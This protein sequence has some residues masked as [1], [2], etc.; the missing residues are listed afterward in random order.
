MSTT[1]SGSTTLGP[2]QVAIAYTE[3]DIITPSTVGFNLTVDA[4]VISL[5]FTW[6]G[7]EFTHEGDIPDEVIGIELLNMT[8]PGD[9]CCEVWVKYVSNSTITST[10]T[11]VITSGDGVLEHPAL[12]VE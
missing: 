8:L 11:W 1:W 7:S 2:D 4:P 5:S 12:T 9:D 6:D 10:A 3:V